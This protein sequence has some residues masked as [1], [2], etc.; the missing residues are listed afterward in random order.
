MIAFRHA[1]PRLP[2]FWEDSRQPAGRWNAEGAG[3]VQY[4]A[5]TP[6]G[7]WAEFL[8][9][10]EIRTPE[11][12]ATVRRALWAIEIDDAVGAEPA[13]S[14]EVMTGG[15]ASY[16]AC[17]AEA[18]RLRAGG[19]ARFDAPSAALRDA[20]GFQV[21]GGLV[22]GDFRAARAIVLFGVPAGA[23]G[24]RAVHEGRP[25]QELLGRVRFLR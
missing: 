4:L 16:D 21:H 2:F 19:A 9:H 22:A 23:T 17:R 11:D 18:D 5:E 1:D 6:D 3:P 7:A 12:L 10:E 13:L 25:H 24:W 14:N 15:L 8:R 20:R